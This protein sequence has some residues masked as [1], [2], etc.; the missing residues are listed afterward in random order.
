MD[1]QHT[2][3]FSDDREGS[4]DGAYFDGVPLLIIGTFRSEE[5]SPQLAALARSSASE[6]LTVG[7]LPSDAVQQMVRDMLGTQSPPPRLLSFVADRA[8]G[9]PFFAA[10]YLRYLLVVGQLW[11]VDRRWRF[12]ESPAAGLGESAPVAPSPRSLGELVRRRIE[13]LDPETRRVVAAAAVLGRA[14]DVSAL[15]AVS[16]VAPEALQATLREAQERVIFEPAGSEI[17]FSHDKLREI[18]YESVDENDKVILHARAAAALER[19]ARGQS[20]DSAAQLARHHKLAGNHARALALYA[21][22]GE[23]AL[24]KSA[25]KDAAAFFREALALSELVGNVPARERARWHHNLGASLADAGD[26]TE[27]R[28]H[29]ELALELLGRRPPRSQAGLG[30]SVL[31]NVARQA[32]RRFQLPSLSRSGGGHELELARGFNR[33]QQLHYYTGDGLR[34]LHACLESLNLSERAT[35]SPELTIAYAN[36]HAVAGV[37]PAR[38]L[39]DV[40]RGLALANM[41]RAPDAAARTYFLMLSGVYLTGAARWAEAAEVLHDGYR[42][43]QQL[44]FG[45][46]ERELTGAIGILHFFKGE[47]TAARR[48]ADALHEV[49][50]QKDT[51]TQCWAL[52]SRAQVLLAQGDSSAALADAEAAHPL[53]LSLGRPE[54]VW[55]LS[56]RCAAHA[57]LGQIDAADAGSREALDA[58]RQTAAAMH[59]TVDAHGLCAEARMTVD[60]ARARR[61]GGDRATAEALAALAR[62]AGVFPVA[63]PRRDLLRGLSHLADGHRERAAHSFQASLKGARRMSLRHDAAR[64]KAALDAGGGSV[65]DALRSMSAAVSDDS[66]SPS[67]SGPVVRAQSS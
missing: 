42:V 2:L 13:A 47:F 51:H 29:I 10:E 18:A 60:A 23:D 49:A 61:R 21:V 24:S 67:S 59:Y 26:F 9:N 14:F 66:P 45:R 7:R 34:M 56:I 12:S 50:F 17:R 62:V 30:A 55:C 57:R 32:A 28:R 36:A 43:A 6:T 16:D 54:R 37:L 15:S 3:G 46:R 11:S 63:G 33:L 8:E 48:Q 40:Y 25:H 58:I 27:G 20:P 4:A 44:D 65:V 64:A 19:S 31:A 38:R 35:A 52:L 41:T 53:T 1:E 39:V 5:A 22:A